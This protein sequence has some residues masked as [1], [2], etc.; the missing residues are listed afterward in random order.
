MPRHR[1]RS[2][3][4][5]NFPQGRQRN[6]RLLR[7]HKPAPS[8]N[9]FANPSE[10]QIRASAS[11]RR[12]AQSLPVQTARSKFARPNPKYVTV[13]SFSSQAIGG[14]ENLDGTDQIEF[15]DRWNCEDD[16]SASGCS[17][18][19]P[20][21]AVSGGHSGSICSA[22]SRFANRNTLFWRK[23]SGHWQKTPARS[24]YDSCQKLP[25][26]GEGL[27]DIAGLGFWLQW[28]PCS[29]PQRPREIHRHKPKSHRTHKSDSCAPRTSAIR[30]TWKRG[31]SF[32]FIFRNSFVIPSLS[33]F[34]A[35]N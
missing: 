9:H 27:S 29:S 1:C 31:T 35:R 22:A 20:Q 12:P 8:P 4:V 15:I 28:F 30:S 3:Q 5:G 25:L 13:N 16:H 19:P 32:L 14:T 23:S 18:L 6:L 34:S 33:G 10:V 21:I 24:S 26:P 17:A 2:N 11:C 7:R